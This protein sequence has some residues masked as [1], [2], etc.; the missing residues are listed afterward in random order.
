MR[1]PSPFWGNLSHTK[2]SF[3][4][5]VDAMWFG[6]SVDGANI[7]SSDG[8][9]RLPV[10]RLSEDTQSRGLAYQSKAIDGWDHL[11]YLGEHMV[12]KYLLYCIRECL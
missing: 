4:G 7:G 6:S 3:R 12:G 1:I 9:R 2:R 10:L 5:A 8:D 11:Q